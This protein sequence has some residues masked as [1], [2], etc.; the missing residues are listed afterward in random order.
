M[1]LSLRKEREAKLVRL[2]ESLEALNQSREW[3][4]LKKD[5]F[6]GTLESIER[7]IE[8]EASKPEINVQELYRLQGERKVAKKYQL[9][10]LIANYRAELA[11]IRKQSHPP[12]GIGE[13]IT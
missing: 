3:S 12:Q 10:T 6:D 5:L 7:R 2:I 8:Q 9:D 4:T 13:M 1:E 11:N